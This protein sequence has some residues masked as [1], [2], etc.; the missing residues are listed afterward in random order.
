[1]KHLTNHASAKIKQRMEDIPHKMIIYNTALHYENMSVQYE[2][3]SQ[4]EK[5]DI[6][7]CNN[8]IFFLI[9]AQNIDCV[10]TLEAVLTCTH[11]LSFEQK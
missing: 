3:I 1:M 4:S 2:A 10:Y 9:F 11:N 5:K 8:A 7:R 6:F